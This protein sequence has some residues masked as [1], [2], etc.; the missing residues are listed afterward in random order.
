MKMS[1]NGLFWAESDRG[2]ISKSSTNTPPS[3]PKGQRSPSAPVR[4]V[5]HAGPSSIATTNQLETVL[6]PATRGRELE[7]E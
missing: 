5:V 6:I 1:I 2:K 4:L 7:N 3:S